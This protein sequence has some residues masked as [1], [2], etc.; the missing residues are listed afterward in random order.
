V[1]KLQHREAVL[2]IQTLDPQLP[3]TVFG[4]DYL[5]EIAPFRRQRPEAVGKLLE[6]S[7]NIC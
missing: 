1:S 6:R 7:G 2:N 3:Q 5:Q 4:P